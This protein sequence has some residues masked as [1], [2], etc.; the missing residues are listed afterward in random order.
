MVRVTLTAEQWRR[1]RIRAAEQDESMTKLLG[2]ILA[3][4][5]DTGGD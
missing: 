5:A 1:L 4:E 2:A 3:H